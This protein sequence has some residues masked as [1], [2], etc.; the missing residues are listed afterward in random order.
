MPD[1][2]IYIRIQTTKGLLWKCHVEL[3]VNPEIVKPLSRIGN[4]NAL[5]NVFDKLITLN[6]MFFKRT[7][8]CTGTGMNQNSIISY[9]YFGKK[10]LSNYRN[11]PKFYFSFPVIFLFLSFF[12]PFDILVICL[13]PSYEVM[14]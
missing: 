10:A 3:V 9:L 5:N 4:I 2:S 14:V 13:C 7:V 11:V 1:K 8:S 6:G 12:L